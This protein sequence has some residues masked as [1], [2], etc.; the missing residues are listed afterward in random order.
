MRTLSEESIGEIT[1]AN[2][3][4]DKVMAELHRTLSEL[5]DRLTVR[6]ENETVDRIYNLTKEYW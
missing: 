1:S 6:K 3:R 4:L 2:E 5:T